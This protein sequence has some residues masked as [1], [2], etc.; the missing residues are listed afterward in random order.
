MSKKSSALWRFAIGAADLVL[1]PLLAVAAQP[2][3]LVHRVGMINL[4]RSRRTLQST[5]VMPIFDHY[6]YPL[7][8]T[9]TLTSLRDPRPLPGIDFRLEAQ[10]QL[11]EAFSR[12]AEPPSLPQMRVDDSTYFLDNESFGPGDAEIWFHM[13]RHFKP[14]RI[15]EIGSGHSTRLARHAIAANTTA[16]TSYVCEHICIEPYEAPWLEASGATIIRQ[17]VEDVDPAQFDSLGENDI[18]FIDSSH[19]IRPQGDVVVEYLQIIPRLHAGVIVHVHDIF[20]PRDYLDIWVHEHLLLWNE[21]YLLEAYLSDNP[22]VEV[23]L[24]V[25]MM[26][27]EM[28]ALLA[29]ACPHLNPEREP[30]SFYFRRKRAQP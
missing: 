11:L 24:G 7:F 6:Y 15:I 17:R 29:S 8:K 3:R 30:G 22:A 25:N 23:L 26:M 21:Q 18:L 14:Q 5:G 27:H 1:A 20:S 12:V 9:Q 2:M 13:I 4:P 16:D 19:V 28:P 10:K